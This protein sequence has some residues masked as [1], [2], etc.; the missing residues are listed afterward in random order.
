MMVNLCQV[1]WIVMRCI[2]KFTNHQNVLTYRFLYGG[3]RGSSI[4]CLQ[5]SARWTTRLFYCLLA[6]FCTVDDEVLPFFVRVQDQAVES[7]TMKEVFSMESS[8]RIEAIENLG[9]LGGAGRA[10]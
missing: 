5:I 3:R 9:S 4:V 6:D 7:Y 1:S 8:V 10:H 2:Y